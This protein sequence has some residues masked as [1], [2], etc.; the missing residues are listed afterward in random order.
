MG[1][2]HDWDASTSED[3]RE[4]VLQKE[5]EEDAKQAAD[6]QHERDVQSSIDAYNAEKD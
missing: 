5:A 1:R 2:F 6:E 3:E 4:E